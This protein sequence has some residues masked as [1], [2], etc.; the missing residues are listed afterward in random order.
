MN[1]ENAILIGKGFRKLMGP[2]IEIVIHD[3]TTKKI[4]FIE[5]TLSQ[6]KVGDASLIEENID[7]E[8]DEFLECY[9]KI[10]FDG[11]L[12]K[13]ISIPIK[14]SDN[15]IL[16]MCV[17][18]DVSLFKHM[19][20]IADSFLKGIENEQPVS[21]FKNDYQEKIHEFLHRVLKEKGW[22]FNDLNIKKKKEIAN[23]LF[24][25]GAFNEKNSVEY[26]AKLLD[27]GRATL[28]NYLKIWRK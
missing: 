18:C 21:L 25:Q 13:S 2:L 26:I 11:R 19:Q 8:K 10:G 27:M 1:L 23:I 6:R 22:S 14:Q 5:G 7:W 15:S 17:N 28:F 4:T 24:S 16:L 9:S 20:S 12:I 3:L